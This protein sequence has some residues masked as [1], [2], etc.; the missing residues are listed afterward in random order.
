MYVDGHGLVRPCAGRVMIRVGHVLGGLWEETAVVWAARGLRRL[1]TVLEVVWAGLHMG[2]SGLGLAWLG[3]VWN[4][5]E[6]GRSWA[7]ITT[8][9]HGLVSHG[10]RWR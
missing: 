6:L 1:W 8:D 3:M 7:V 2:W 10:L 4:G 5:H 9:D